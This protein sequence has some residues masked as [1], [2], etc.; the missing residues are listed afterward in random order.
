MR[1]T[2]RAWPLVVVDRDPLQVCALGL[3]TKALGRHRITADRY[4]QLRNTQ[5]GVCGI[6]ERGNLRGADAIPLDIDHDHICCPDHHNTCGKC[7][8]GLLCSGCNGFLGEMELWGK[9]PGIDEDGTWER[10]AL[11]YLERAGCPL[12]EERKA[13]TAERHRRKVA[14]WDPPCCCRVCDPNWEQRREQ[15]RAEMRARLLSASAEKDA[16]IRP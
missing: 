1:K 9:V 2:G 12:T 11:A 15:R 10:A 14:L 4:R 6:C 13:A 7:I 5:D 8:R 16:G 3:P